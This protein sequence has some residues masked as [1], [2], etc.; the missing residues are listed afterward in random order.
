MTSSDNS[1][2]P[3]PEADGPRYADRAYR[4]VPGLIG[5]VLLL[6]VA[7]WLTGDAVVQGRGRTPWLALAALLT[8]A[9]VVVAFTLRPV[10][11]AGEDRLL[12][13]NPFRSITLPWAAVDEVRAGY[14]TEVL[15]AGVKYQMW[16][17]PVSLRQRKRATRRQER[18]A[19][20]HPFGHGG[21]AGGAGAD[22]D[23]SW[24]D[25]AVDELRGLVE[26]N[27]EREGAAGDVSVRWAVEVIAPAVAGAVVLLVLSLTG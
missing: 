16:A 5:G 2:T 6:A 24:S 23:K 9:P 12:V 4:S 3:G 19:V 10:V 21:G 1:S 14:S 11:L 25:A 22:A 8:V 7:V 15:A 26:R 20:Q 27:R 13:R 17:I 18:A